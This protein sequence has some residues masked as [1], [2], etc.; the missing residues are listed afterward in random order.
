MIFLIDDDSDDRDIFEEA[1]RQIKVNIPFQS[2]RDGRDALN[3]MSDDNFPVPHMIFLDLN[4]PR[5]NG[6]EFL[7]TVK[8]IDKYCKVPIIVYSTSSQ[9]E[10]K[11]EVFAL[12][13]TDYMVKHK[14]FTELCGEL[15]YMIAKNLS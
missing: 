9:A 1:L 15:D 14:S 11:K 3:Q 7:A 6:K 5:M 8:Q 4:M 13:A 2:A 10:E 12:G